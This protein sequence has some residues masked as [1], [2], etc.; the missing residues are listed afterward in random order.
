MYHQYHAP[1]WWKKLTFIAKSF[2]SK[3]KWSR[4]LHFS[5]KIGEN[6]V[7]IF[8]VFWGL[9]WAQNLRADPD[10]KCFK[11]RKWMRS[12]IFSFHSYFR[13][14]SWRFSLDSLVSQVVRTIGYTVEYLFYTH[15]LINAHFLINAPFHIFASHLINDT[16]HMS[17]HLLINAS[18]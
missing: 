4:E 3:V 17:A 10:E 16:F 12:S 15:H 11:G 9:K 7:P 6:G 2:L 14:F 5:T 8:I 13:G 1:H 18:F